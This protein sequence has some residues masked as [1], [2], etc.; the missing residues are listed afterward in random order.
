[1]DVFTGFKTGENVLP[2]A[3][4]QDLFMG[5]EFAFE[6]LGSQEIEKIYL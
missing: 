2:H 6:D 4:N 1:M 5:S 3:I